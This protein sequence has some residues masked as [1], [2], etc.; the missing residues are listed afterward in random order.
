MPQCVETHGI[1]IFVKDESKFQEAANA[2]RQFSKEK[3][4]GEP[5]HERHTSHSQYKN[6]LSQSKLGLS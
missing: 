3:L 4:G 2:F 5:S 6:Q 1:R